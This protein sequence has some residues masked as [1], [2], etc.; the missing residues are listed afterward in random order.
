MIKIF[1]SLVFG[2][3]II[4]YTTIVN[5][6]INNNSGDNNINNNSNNI[7]INNIKGVYNSDN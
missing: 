6:N 7:S 5:N 3:N 2:Y 4:E 1:F